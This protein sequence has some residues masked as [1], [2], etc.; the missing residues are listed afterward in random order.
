[1]VIT[2]FLQPYQ[3]TPLL[4]HPRYIL[5]S[6]FYILKTNERQF[7]DDRLFT[8]ALDLKLEALSCLRSRYHCVHHSP[9]TQ[10]AGIGYLTVSFQEESKKDVS[11][12]GLH[13]P[14]AC[15]NKKQARK[16]RLCRR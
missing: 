16:L 6:Q 2:A 5:L 7:M 13:E 1:M 11:K 10:Q 12:Y 9:S 8:L 3:N 14:M 4:H 15:E